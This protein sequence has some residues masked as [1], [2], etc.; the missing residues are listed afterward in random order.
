M[1]QCQMPN[2]CTR[3]HTIFSEYKQRITANEILVDEMNR[4]AYST[5][6]RNFRERS[7]VCKPSDRC[8]EKALNFDCDLIP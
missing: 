5:Q 4:G 8:S 2:T 1:S 6:H 7:E 3:G